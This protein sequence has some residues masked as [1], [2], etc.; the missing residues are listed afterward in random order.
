MH[1]WFLTNFTELQLTNIRANYWHCGPPNQ[2]FWWA[3][4][5]RLI[6]QLSPMISCHS[7]NVHQV[8]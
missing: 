4:A 6:L 8:P 7:K 5:H 3:M 2:N 1:I